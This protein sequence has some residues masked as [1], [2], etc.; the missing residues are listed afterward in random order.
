MPSEAPVSDSIEAERSTLY[1]LSEADAIKLSEL[2]L[3]VDTL[4]IEVAALKN[5]SP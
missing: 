3:R 4:E 5:S 1:A 2:I